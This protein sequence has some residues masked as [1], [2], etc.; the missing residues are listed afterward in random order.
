[1]FCSFVYIMHIK[2]SARKD[3]YSQDC[4]F[5]NSSFGLLYSMSLLLN[6]VN[7]YV[8]N[9]LKNYPKDTLPV[10]KIAGVWIYE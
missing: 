10:F 1:M 2:T 8:P 5:K 6:E 9:A 3:T 4:I 7:K